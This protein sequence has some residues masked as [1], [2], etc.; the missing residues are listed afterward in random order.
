MTLS[1][2]ATAGPAAA[3]TSPPEGDVQAIRAIVGAYESGWNAHDTSAIAALFADDVQW[4]NIVGMWWRGRTEVSA[5]HVGI[6][7]TPPCV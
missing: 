1:D 2:G 7:A 3:S 4:V 6:P 5:A